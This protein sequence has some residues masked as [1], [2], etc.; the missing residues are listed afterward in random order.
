MILAHA[1]WHASFPPPPLPSLPLP[2]SLSLVSDSPPLSSVF[3]RWNPLVRLIQ[4]R[5]TLDSSSR[6]QLAVTKIDFLARTREKARGGG[7]DIAGRVYRT[8]SRPSFDFS[9]LSACAC[10][11]S[12]PLLHPAQ[13]SHAIDKKKRNTRTAAA[14]ALIRRAFSLGPGPSSCNRIGYSTA[15]TKMHF[16]RTSTRSIACSN[17]HTGRQGACSLLLFFAHAKARFTLFRFAGSIAI[18]AIDASLRVRET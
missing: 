5:F 7:G 11:L 4:A 1:S 15:D 17:S 12:P 18:I 2:L 8:V 16:R 14:A 3:R 6:A 13:I 10:A 9:V